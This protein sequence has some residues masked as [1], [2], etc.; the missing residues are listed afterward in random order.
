MYRLSL[1][2]GFIPNTSVKIMLH[3]KSWCLGN[4][5]SDLKYHNFAA[6]TQGKSLQTYCVV[7]QPVFFCQEHLFDSYLN[8]LYFAITVSVDWSC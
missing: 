1:N 4:S 8:F 3:S 6:N 2:N 7:G 5:K